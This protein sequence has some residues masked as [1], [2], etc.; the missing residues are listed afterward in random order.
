VTDPSVIDQLRSLIRDVP[1]FP[2]PGIVF[3]DLTPVFAHGPA[4]QSLCASLAARYRDRPVDAFVGIESRGFVVAAPLAVELGKGLVLARKPGKLPGA[5]RSVSYA[6]EYGHDRLE[7][8]HD[9]LAPG[10]RVVVV[11]DVLA[12]GGTAGAAIALA[13][14]A[15]AEVLEAAFVI[16]LAFLEGRRRLDAAAFSLLTF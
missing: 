6:L 1:D 12:T 14:E 11:D 13:R 2:R 10:M 9:A 4:Q 16:E 7:M 3:K 15:G 8:Q 5:T